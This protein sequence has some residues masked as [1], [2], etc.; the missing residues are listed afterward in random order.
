MLT[1]TPRVA[2]I[3]RC[4]SLVLTHRCVHRLR[5]R[6]G[7]PPSSVCCCCSEGRLKGPSPAFEVPFN[8]SSA[9]LLSSSSNRPP[10]PPPSSTPFLLPLP[11]LS[12]S[13]LF[14][15][16]RSLPPCWPS[17]TAPVPRA[18]HLSSIPAIA[19]HLFQTS[20]GSNFF[21]SFLTWKLQSLRRGW[22]FIGARRGLTVNTSV[23]LACHQCY[24]TDSSLAC[25]WHFLKL[26]ARSFLRVL[27]FPPLLHRLM[28]LT[29]I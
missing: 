3:K 14:Q 11:T 28:V 23:F 12:S 20:H 10:P 19:V 22:Q 2:S 1:V 4:T 21:F 9:C 13:N 24:C 7:V 18:A 27:R 6:Q 17:G 29:I 25:M 5:Q 8:D 15:S 26:V 16:A